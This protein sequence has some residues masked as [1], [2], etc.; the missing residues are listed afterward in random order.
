MPVRDRGGL[1]AEI[2]NSPVTYAP[3]TELSDD[4][5]DTGYR[6]N[7]LRLWLAADDSSAYLVG[8]DRTERWPASEAMFRCG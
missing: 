1:F 5:I 8:P 2:D 3:D 4:A 6:R 7:G